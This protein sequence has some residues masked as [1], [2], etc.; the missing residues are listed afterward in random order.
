MAD[1]ALLAPF[2]A[3]GRVVVETADMD[4]PSRS[5]IS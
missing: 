2:R 4:T 1:E 3:L 5:T